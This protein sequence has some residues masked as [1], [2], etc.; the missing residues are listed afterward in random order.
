MRVN[1]LAKDA[2]DAGA[3]TSTRDAVVLLHRHLADN[4]YVDT[5]DVFSREASGH[6]A[7]VSVADEI[8]LERI[9]REHELHHVKKRG[10]TPRLYKRIGGQHDSRG[11]PQDSRVGKNLV[12]GTKS[13]AVVSGHNSSRTTT[14]TD[15]QKPKTVE[16]S[17]ME[18][19][20]SSA[21]RTKEKG[22]DERKDKTS[23]G[24]VGTNV[25]NAEPSSRADVNKNASSSSKTNNDIEYDFGSDDLNQLGSVVQR[26]ILSDNPDVL[27]DDVAGLNVAKNLLKEAVV[28]PAKYPQLFTGLL[29]PWKGVLLHGPPGT[30]KTLLAKAVATECNSVFF[31]ISA[32]TVV[33]KYRGDSEK[34]I[35]V[36][37][38]LA[39]LK[40]PSVVFMDEIDALM[41]ERGGG[42]G[43]EHEASRR[44]KTELL[45]QLDGLGS[46]GGEPVRTEH[47]RNGNECDS[48]NKNRVFLLAATN[49]P[50]ALDP[51]LLRRMEKRILVPLP[52]VEARVVMFHKLLGDRPKDSGVCLESLAWETESY[53]GSDIA[54]L[55]KEVAMRPVR[56]LVKQLESNDTKR[57][58]E[59]RVG[60]ITAEDVSSAMSITKPSAANQRDK[61]A[62]WSLRFGQS[63]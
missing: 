40:S 59:Q 51:A 45:I 18:T 32:S 37:F 39:T 44:M 2:R 8:S 10:V 21:S 49:T 48:Q 1:T 12:V 31:N 26:D 28:A 41:S 4:G 50:W 6:L 19:L 60:P 15:R 9:F 54:V 34:L 53:S 24:V 3:K 7:G 13:S 52:D 17:S 35:R 20:R 63:C 33:S 61:H 56:R 47:P 11:G 25:T 43:G 29:T 22:F 46:R 5:A 14:Q 42:G 57:T 62:E 30:G 55:C 27:W 38:E 23:L 36:L 16:R 58:P